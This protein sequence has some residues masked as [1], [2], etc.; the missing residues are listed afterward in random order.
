LGVIRIGLSNG[1]LCREGICWDV[2]L[3]VEGGKMRKDAI[4]SWR[5]G[6]GCLAICLAFNASPAAAQHGNLR[7]VVTDSAGAPI[8][9]AAVSIVDL[10]LLTRTDERG[11]FALLHLPAGK[12]EL[13]VRRL[14]YEPKRLPIVITATITDSM[15]VWLA[16]QPAVLST[17]TTSVAERRRRQGIEDF[18]ARRARGVGTYITREDIEHRHFGLPSDMLR[19]TPGI[20]FVR[21]SGGGRGV[22][23]PTTSITR[24][25][26]A[27]MIWIDGQKAPGLEIDD[28]PLTDIEGIELYSGPSTT[29]LQFSQSS[30]SST[31]GALVVWTRPPPPR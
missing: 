25:D 12:I 27:P 15:V 30:A 7:G 17:I 29:P 23:F 14:G 28:L 9:Q 2:G 11:R 21:L 10:R 24:R 26:C 6:V 1:G 3:Q 13:T 18:H 20:R 22:R 16:A 4:A 19:N 31:C 5:L 8:K